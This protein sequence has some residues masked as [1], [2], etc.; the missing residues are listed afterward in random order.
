MMPDSLQQ[1]V[2]IVDDVAFNLEILSHVLVD[3][4]HVVAATDGA[5]ALQMAA[6]KPPDIILLDIMM[7]GMDGYEVCRRLKADKATADI[8]LIFVTALDDVANE[9]QGFELGAVDYITKP[10]TPAV[11]R[12]RVKTHLALKGAR[13][14]LESTIKNLQQALAEIHTLRG[15]VPICSSCKKIRDDQGFW[16]QVEKYVEQ[17]SLAEFS[18]SFCPECAEKD[19]ER[20]EAYIARKQMS[21]KIRS[22]PAGNNQSNSA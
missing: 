9:T 8:P 20:L 4:Y 5:T 15:I 21:K 12:A 13:T 3:N 6:A 22:K 7:P 2:L 16:N 14:E 11:V 19:L 10:I 1:T 18:H 17:R